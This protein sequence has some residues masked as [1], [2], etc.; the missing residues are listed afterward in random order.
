MNKSLKFLQMNKG[1][2]ELYSRTDQ[3]KDIIQTHRPSIF[4]INELN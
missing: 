4:I 2:S 3:L 1:N